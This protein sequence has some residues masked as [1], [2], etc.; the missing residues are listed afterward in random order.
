MLVNIFYNTDKSVN[1]PLINNKL[2]VHLNLSAPFLVL[3]SNS[4]HSTHMCYL[5]NG[6]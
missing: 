2:S 1:G 5:L 6:E 3:S 4:A